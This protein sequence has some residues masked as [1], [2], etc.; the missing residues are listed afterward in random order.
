MIHL[1]HDFHVSIIR[2][3]DGQHGIILLYYLIIYEDMMLVS[4]CIYYKIRKI[5][6]KLG[7]K[8]VSWIKTLTMNGDNIIIVG[9]S[10]LQGKCKYFLR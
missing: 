3:Y 9:I 2:W 5:K 4:S 7:I 8:N 10:H 6:K 1:I